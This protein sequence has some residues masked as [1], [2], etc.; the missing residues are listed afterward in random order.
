LQNKNNVLPFRK[1]QK[2]GLI[3]PHA[4]A[5]A[6]LTGNYLGQQCADA[7]GSFDCVETPLQA[8]TLANKGGSVQVAVGCGVDD[9]STAG[10]AEAVQVAQTSDIIVLLMGLDT[11]GVERE[12][13]DRTSI[14]LPGVQLQLIQAIVKAAGSKPLALV[15][16]NGGAVGLDW[17]K[18]NVNGIVDAFY[19][20]KWGASAIA[21]VLFGDYNPGGKLPYTMYSSNYVNQIA[22]EDM[23]M[24]TGVGRTYRYFTGTPLWPFGFGLSYTTFEFSFGVGTDSAIIVDVLN[25]GKRDGDEVVEVYF[26]PLDDV[27]LNHPTRLPLLQLVDFER[28]HVEAGGKT[29]STFTISDNTVALV[30]GQG[31]LVVAPG[32]YAFTFTNGADQKLTYN[33]KVAE[34]ERIIEPFPK[35]T[36]N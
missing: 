16:L 28:V 18:A 13:H 6:A 36:S 25:T 22:F 5:Q 9:N 15:L 21:D 8:L 4:K 33:Y 30:D 20:G 23:N 2:L 10:F 14:D 31:N 24:T 35:Q 3:G 7:F 27:K 12:G 26:T 34:P 29:Q 19:P 17:V 32:S 11:S 1:G